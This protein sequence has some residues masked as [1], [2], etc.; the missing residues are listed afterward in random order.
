VRNANILSNVYIYSQEQ[1]A[2]RHLQIA[3][4]KYKEE[5]AAWV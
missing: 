1:L 2:G 3:V 5:E 4:I